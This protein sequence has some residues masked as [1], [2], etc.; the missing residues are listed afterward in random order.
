MKIFREKSNQLSFLCK[1]GERDAFDDMQEKER[2]FLLESKHQHFVG[3][4]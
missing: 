3:I 1:N 4:S 2:D